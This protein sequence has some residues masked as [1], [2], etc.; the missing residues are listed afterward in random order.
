M[1]VLLIGFSRYIL[2]VHYLTDIVSG[3]LFGGIILI[4]FI[5]IYKKI[6]QLRLGKT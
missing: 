3:F 5:K 1:L 2:N 4:V 6:V